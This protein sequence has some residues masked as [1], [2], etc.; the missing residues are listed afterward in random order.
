M[1]HA[2]DLRMFADRKQKKVEDMHFMQDRRGAVID[3]L[4]SDA[5]KHGEK[6]KPEAVPVKEVEPA[7]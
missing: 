5:N 4:L 1:C 6:T 3:T 7:K 2:R